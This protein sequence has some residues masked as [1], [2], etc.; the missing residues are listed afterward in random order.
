MKT[1]LFF[2]FLIGTQV[3]IVLGNEL[4]LLSVNDFL[5]KTDSTKMV[6]QDLGKFEINNNE[7]ITLHQIKAEKRRPNSMRRNMQ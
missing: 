5:Q 7:L 6:H 3:Q 2:I 4:T 1:T